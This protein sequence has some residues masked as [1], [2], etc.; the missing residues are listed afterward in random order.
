MRSLVIK[1][2]W[3]GG[4][5]FQKELV[6]FPLAYSIVGDDVHHLVNVCR[7]KKDE[8]LLLLNGQGGVFYSK[9]KEIQKK[10]IQLEVYSV[11]QKHLYCQLEVMVPYV[12]R[13]AF[14]EMMRQAV[15]LG[16]SKMHTLS[17]AFSQAACSV[18][19][20]RLQNIIH[21][22]MEQSNNPFF[23]DCVDHQQS[24][25]FLLKSPQETFFLQF[26]SIVVFHPYEVE[27][28]KTFRHLQQKFS[29]DQK[30]LVLVGPEG[31]FS[32]EELEKLSLMNNVFFIQLPVPLLRA[33]HGIS[34][35][36]GTLLSMY[37]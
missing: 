5:V 6:T 7:I 18:R 10:S 19:V 36:F 24:L 25:L 33:E 34:V 1:K 21:S 29:K 12:K 26:D 23:I 3:P 11:E 31:G 2:D 15:E 27:G 30:I 8:P 22:S 13:P 16:L 37:L 32:Q 17:S 20:D 35:G 9:I 4:E 28:E 14:E